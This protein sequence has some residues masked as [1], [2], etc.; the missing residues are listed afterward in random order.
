[1]NPNRK[2]GRF[3]W[4]IERLGINTQ[5]ADRKLQLK[6]EPSEEVPELPIYE[7]TRKIPTGRMDLKERQR[8]REQMDMLDVKRT[9]NIAKKRRATKQRFLKHIMNLKEEFKRKQEEVEE[10]IQE[11]RLQRYKAKEEME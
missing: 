10:K 11:E 6:P 8:L 4:T 3:H 7:T 9:E 1:M 5:S 2:E